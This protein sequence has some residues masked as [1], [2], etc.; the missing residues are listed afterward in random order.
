MINEKD[1]ETNATN[2][3]LEIHPKLEAFIEV[4]PFFHDLIPQ[5]F[6][7]GV[8]NTTHLIFGSGSETIPALP[9]GYELIPGDGM[10]EAVRD[11]EIQ[12]VVLPDEIFGFP[13]M[14]NTIPI[15]DN[16]GN[17]IGSVGLAVSMEQYNILYGI[18]AKLSVAIEEVSATIQE[19]ASSVTSSASNVQVISE[20]SESVLES[21]E[22][23]DHLA[24]L[25]KE[26]SERSNILGLNASIESARAG[27]Y[28]RGFAVVAE[29]IR[30]MATNSRQHSETINMS[31]QKINELMTNLHQSIS[32]ISQES[33]SQSAAT[34][35]MAATI[36]E[37]N[38][39]AIYLSNYA[40]KILNGEV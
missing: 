40:K 21:V 20:Q 16:D 10:Y 24:S 2:N 22:E 38:E 26:V 15:R 5:D 37:I 25:V 19:L 11:N 3:E 36:Q 33:E 34:E 23:I 17:A 8:S 28:G 18:A 29:E 1:I 14:G 35:E 7:C 13:V 32:T 30:K 39:N 6:S 12:R 9:I 31:T 4:I 27:E